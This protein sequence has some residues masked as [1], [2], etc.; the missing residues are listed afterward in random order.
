LRS[1]KRTWLG[2]VL[3]VVVIGMV[4]LLSS[5]GGT[6]DTATTVPPEGVTTTAPAVSDLAPDQTLIE[7]IKEE[8]PSLDP[9]IAT[10]TTSSCIINNIFEGL[11][12]MAPDGSVFPGLAEKWEVSP[13]GLTYTFY[14]RGTDKWTNG[15]VVTSQDFKN[16]WTRILDP[17]TAGQYAY[18]LYY[19][20]GATEWNDG[21]GTADKLAI[22]ATDPKVLKVTLTSKV[23]WFVGL[24]A[25]TAYFPVPLKT[26][27]Q[28]GD[29]WTEPANIVTCGPFKL[30]GWNHASDLTMEKSADWRDA[31]KV[32][33]TKIT[34]VMIGEETTGVA[35]FENGEID[36]QQQ[37]PV[38]DIDRIKTLPEY[39]VFPYLGVYYMGFNTT[40]PALAKVE[41][42]QALGM[43]ID[44]Q[45]IIDNVVKQGQAPATGWA[46]PG[47]PGFDTFHKDNW[48]ASPDVAKAKELLAAAGYPDGAGLPEITI[49]YNTSESHQA[50]MEAIQEQWK[51]IGVK[52]VLKNMEWKQYIDFLPKDPS[53]QAYRMGWIADYVDAENFYGLLTTKSGNNYTRWGS[54]TYDDTLKG[55]LDAATES[56]RYK[57]YGQLEQILA[58]EAPATPIYWYTNPQL[59]K[60]YVKGYAPNAMS[61]TN[62][63]TI[64]ILKH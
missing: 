61:M 54:T 62:F 53:V 43:A 2:L 46:P 27:E 25:H 4:G 42:R 19:I 51:A 6:D 23:P 22:D 32:T 20:K 40:N 5:C 58:D 59:V 47:L 45:G 16:S 12:R 1:L 50:I 41:V 14:L 52:S 29:K 3:V 48:P 63:E 18:E 38:A 44:R 64:S 24:M 31:S 9:N 28:F 11:T 39:V 26:I 33:L 15:D 60:L 8:P 57:A 34:K 35:A 7:N 56:D 36:I 55:S 10:D 21:S 13:D 49:F 37:L 17:K 30:T